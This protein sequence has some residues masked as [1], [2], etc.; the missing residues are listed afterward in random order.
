M[1]AILVLVS[2][3]FLLLAAGCENMR[4][5][6]ASGSVAVAGGGARVAVAFS[7]R[8]RQLIHEHYAGKR[9]KPLPP[10]L[11][12]REHLPP[13]LE[14]Q[15]RKDGQLPPG[16]R[17]EPLPYALESRLSPLPQ[18]YARIVVG[19]SVVL[20]NTGTRVVVDIIQD[21]AAD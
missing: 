21:I 12:K 9:R 10:G 1:R 8:D 6:G 5:V 20:E 3:S 7:E 15:L 13:G 2:L 17:R 14:R 18:G 19:G 11:A 16:L 4:I